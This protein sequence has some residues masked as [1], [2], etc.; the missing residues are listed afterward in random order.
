MARTSHWLSRSEQLPSPRMPRRLALG[1][2]LAVIALAIAGC[3]RWEPRN[4]EGVRIV[5]TSSQ[6]VTVVVLYPSPAQEL[7]L[8]TYR[9][10]EESVENRMIGEGGCTRADMVARTEDGREI[11]R[12][13]APACIDEEWLIDD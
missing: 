11:D 8:V 9:P 13:P 3:L 1:V 7:E 6:R 2:L 4:T 10:G 5:N 12:Q